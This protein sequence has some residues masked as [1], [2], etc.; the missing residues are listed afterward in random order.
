M[1]LMLKE[2]T[3]FMASSTLLEMLSFLGEKKRI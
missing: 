3:Q 1:S 2:Y